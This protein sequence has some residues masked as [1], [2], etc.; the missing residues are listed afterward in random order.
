MYL[1]GGRWEGIRGAIS[2][3]AERLEEY[4]FRYLSGYPSPNGDFR[5]AEP[6]E[7]REWRNIQ[8]RRRG[9]CDLGEDMAGS[10]RVFRIRGDSSR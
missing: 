8:Y 5:V 4:T 10:L 3:H 6:G 1:E 7:M 2:G 9:D